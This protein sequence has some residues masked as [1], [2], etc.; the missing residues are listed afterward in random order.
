[1]RK[2]YKVIAAVAIIA[3]AGWATLSHLG[4][5]DIEERCSRPVITAEEWPVKAGPPPTPA[6][7]A[8]GDGRIGADEI[9]ALAAADP[10]QKK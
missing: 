9:A 3:T 4:R 10:Y 5:I 7:Q 6:P 2:L 1:M 8:Q